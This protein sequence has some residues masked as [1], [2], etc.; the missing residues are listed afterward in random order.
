MR[1]KEV[2]YGLGSN[3]FICFFVENV[4]FDL[5]KNNLVILIGCK[6]KFGF[7]LDIIFGLGKFCKNFLGC[8]GLLMEEIRNF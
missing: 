5:D 2:I 7:L 4:N 8:F 3:V 1:I 6:M